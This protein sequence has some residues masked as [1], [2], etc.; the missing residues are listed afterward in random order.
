MGRCLKSR[1]RQKY[2]VGRGGGSS[3]LSPWRQGEEV[4]GHC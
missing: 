1:G 3:S 4:G 2:K